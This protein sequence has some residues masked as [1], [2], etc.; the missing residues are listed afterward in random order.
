MNSED[1]TDHY[2][3]L[4]DNIYIVS[5][6]YFA[7][8]KRLLLHN[9]FSQWTL[10]LLSLGL[11]IIPL[12]I[13]TKIPLRFQQNIIDFASIG[14]AVAV[15]MLS[16]LIGANNYSLRG[17]KMYQTGLEL[18]ELYRDMKQF[19][20]NDSRMNH[21]SKFSRRY[22]DILRRYENVD[23]IDYIKGKISRIRDKPIPLMLQINY[24]FKL[25]L[26]M[27]IYIIA[28]ILEFGFIGLLVT[29]NV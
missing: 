25:T 17:E 28:L 16:L 6:N 13:V 18:N 3:K 2:K 9:S 12:L 1:D 27:I 22:S 23:D 11:I 7:A 5:K 14:L 10:S 19:E 15:L 26:E 4:S 24:Y 8:N 20:S 21:F 29:K